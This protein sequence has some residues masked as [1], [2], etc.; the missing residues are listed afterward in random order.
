MNNNISNVHYV[1]FRQN[2][3]DVKMLQHIV[4]YWGEIHT[5]TQNQEPNRQGIGNTSIFDFWHQ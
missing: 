3:T 4:S 5:H 2:N 1:K